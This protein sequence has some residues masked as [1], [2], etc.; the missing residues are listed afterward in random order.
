MK[1]IHGL[2]DPRCSLSAVVSSRLAAIA[3]ANKAVQEEVTRQ[4]AKRGPYMKLS[5]SS[6]RCEITKDAGQHGAAEA[7]QHFS[8]K[9][10]KRVGESTVKSTKKA[11]CLILAVFNFHRWARATNVKLNENEIFL[12]QKFPDTY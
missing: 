7:A 6:Q 9:L 1:P 10:E 8:R 12:A 11:T 2:P 3:E 5:Y 4:A